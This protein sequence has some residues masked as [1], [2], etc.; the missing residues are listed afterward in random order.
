LPRS[1]KSPLCRGV[2]VGLAFALQHAE[3]DQRIEEVA[4][5]ARVQAES[6]DQDFGSPGPSP[7]LG[8]QAEF[9]RAEERLRSPEGEAELQDRIGRHLGNSRACGLPWRRGFRTREAVHKQAV[10][11]QGIHG[12]SLRALPDG[13]SLIPWRMP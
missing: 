6:F 1:K 11:A 3:R 13:P 10:L 12:V 7:E 9:D 5:G 2:R 4:G 8:E